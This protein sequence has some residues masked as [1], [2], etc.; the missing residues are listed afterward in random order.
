MLYI[1]SD[2]DVPGGGEADEDGLGFQLASARGL[3]RPRGRGRY[4]IYDV[5]DNDTS[6]QAG[7]R[8]H[9]T[10]ILGRLRLTFGGDTDGI[11]INARYSF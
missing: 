11:G 8:Y 10:E 3:P 7:A 6:L 4:P 1:D 2:V 9:F 5:S